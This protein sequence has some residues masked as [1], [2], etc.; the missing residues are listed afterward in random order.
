MLLVKLCR[1]GI[2]ETWCSRCFSCRSNLL[3][4]SASL[5]SSTGTWRITDTVIVSSQGVCGSDLIDHREHEAA[6]EASHKMLCAFWSA[7]WWLFFLCGS[8]WI[9]LL[10]DLSHQAWCDADL[11]KNKNHKDSKSQHFEKFAAEVE[12]L[13]ASIADLTEQFAAVPSN[14]EVSAKIEVDETAVR[15]EHGLLNAQT[16]PDTVARVEAVQKA[17][18]VLEDS[19]DAN[20]SL[21]KVNRLRSTCRG[22]T[23]DVASL[24]CW[25]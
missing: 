2:L 6:A 15:K 1:R 17:V 3:G 12:Q 19:H 23:A 20:S 24:I 22:M 18:H 9:L 13:E 4:T 7:K 11:H 25:K 16:V 14:L 8:L 5:P 10:P 21:I